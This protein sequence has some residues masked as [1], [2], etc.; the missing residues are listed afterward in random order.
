M[1]RGG[2]G[3]GRRR[4]PG[5]NT[6]QRP[7]RRL[8]PAPPLAHGVALPASTR[9]SFLASPA[10]TCAV[11]KITGKEG[12]VFEGHALCFD[13]EED[14]LAALEKDQEQFKASR[15]GGCTQQ[16]CAGGGG[17]RG[18]GLFC[19]QRRSCVQ[20]GVSLAA[21]QP[22][23]PSALVAAAVQLRAGGGAR[24]RCRS[25]AAQQC[26]CLP[27]VARSPPCR[28]LWWSSGTRGPRA[29]PACPRCSHPPAP[30]WVLAWATTAR[31]SPTDASGEPRPP[32]VHSVCCPDLCEAW[33]AMR[34]GWWLGPGVRPYPQRTARLP[35]RSALMAPSRRPA[36]G[37]PAALTSF[38]PAP[39]ATA[40]AP[41]AL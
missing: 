33:V 25:T 39:H 26:A 8:S 14:M 27:A 16:R 30:S 24:R 36:C 11:G 19:L 20:S 31:S 17:P 22:R 9:V 4:T 1:G 3:G 15:G 12:M 13:C 2:R 32:L 29:A 18:G 7:R 23:A 10:P 37:A 40:A 6:A 5:H 34:A 21:A 35:P 41:M 28:A 38:R